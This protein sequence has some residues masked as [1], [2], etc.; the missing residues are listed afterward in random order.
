[1]NLNSWVSLFCPVTFHQNE[2]IK[3]KKKVDNESQ[4][5]KKSS[6]SLTVSPKV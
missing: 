2:K 5:E 4:P 1:M 6:F 3:K